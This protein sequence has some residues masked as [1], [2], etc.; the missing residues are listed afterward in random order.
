MENSKHSCTGFLLP[1]INR[2]VT[3]SQAACKTYRFARVSPISEIMLICI[4]MNFQF[5]I[6]WCRSTV[7]SNSP[8]FAYIKK[9]SKVL[10]GGL[11]FL[12]TTKVV[13]IPLINLVSWVLSYLGRGWP[14]IN[15][16]KGRRPKKGNSYCPLKNI[17]LS[18][19]IKPMV[20]KGFYFVSMKTDLKR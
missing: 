20:F 14:L 11:P 10:R 4:R 9:Y 8:F 2:C 16:S 7:H 5:Q 6:N 18:H 15:N 3:E 13:S 19:G 17:V 1:F 12:G